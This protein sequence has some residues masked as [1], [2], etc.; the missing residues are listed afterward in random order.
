V[1]ASV[2]VVTHSGPDRLDDGLA[3]LNRYANRSDVEV[4]LVDNGAPGGL[5]DQA[6]RRFPWAR[7]LRSPKNLGF[8]GGA[9]LGAE[10]AQGDVLLFLNDDAAA[11]PG[12]VEAHLEAL[13][14]HPE[15]AASG[16]RLVTWDR[17]R[18][19]FLRG[20]VT[21]DAHAFQ[22][23]QGWPVD[24]LP[25]PAAGEPLPFACGGNAAIRRSDW[26]AVGGFDPELF[27]YF[28]DVELGWQLWSMDRAVVAAPDAVARHRGAATSSALGDFRRGVLFERNA[29]RI[30]YCCADDAHRSALGNAVYTTFLHRIVAFAAS[31][32]EW[33]PHVTDPFGSTGGPEGWRDRW[34]SRVREQGVV[35]AARHVLARILLG[36]KAGRPRIDD[37]HLLMQLR[38]AHGFFEGIGDTETR[39]REIQRRRVVADRDLAVRFPRLVVPTYE[40][41][42][43]WFASDAFRAL[44]PGDWPIEFVDLDDILHPTLRR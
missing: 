1:K 43:D 26:V 42:R 31:R 37:G 36:P 35:A 44:L 40:G 14:L 5:S 9:N 29:L 7:V 34:G 18:H 22:I 11:E 32:P 4:I 21:F 24:Q 20:R 33:A 38:A 12:F 27:A 30:F 16:G 3:S 17:S 28:E 25:M 8:A 10:A 41:D 2:I 19:D 6:G 15:A 13:D 23:G 39:R